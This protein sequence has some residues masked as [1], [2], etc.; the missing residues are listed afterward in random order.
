MCRFSRGFSC[1]FSCHFLGHENPTPGLWEDLF[2][3][4][5]SVFREDLFLYNSSLQPLLERA[6]VVHLADLGLG[7][8]KSVT[9]GRWPHLVTGHT[10]LLVTPNHKSPPWGRLYH[11]GEVKFS[12]RHPVARFLYI[13]LG[14]RTCANI[15]CL[16]VYRWRNVTPRWRNSPPGG[17]ISFPMVI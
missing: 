13:Q 1:H 7:K 10:W 4:S 14:F 5:E 2:S 9:S 12:P 17:E 3:Y 8:G 11:R 6:P 16:L 15:G